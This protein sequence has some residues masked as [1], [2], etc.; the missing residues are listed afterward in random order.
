MKQLTLIVILFM[1]ISAICAETIKL[2]RQKVVDLALERNET[3]KSELLEQDRVRGQYIEARAGAFPHLTF[4]GSYLR[5]I[6]LQTSVLTM[7]NDEGETEK[8]TLRF[9]TPHNYSLGLT[10][11]QPLYAAGK[12]GAA[13]KIAKYGFAY[14]DEQLLQLGCR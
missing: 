5:N 3:Y 13:I 2:D 9:G 1:S 8:T 14:T 12:V 6:D 10:L 11:Y 7:T 4:N